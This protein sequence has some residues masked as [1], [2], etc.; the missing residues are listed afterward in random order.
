MKQ[1]DIF[2]GGEGDAWLTR[3]PHLGDRDPVLEAIVHLGLKP[4]SVFEIGCSNGWRLAALRDKFGCE[5]CGVDPSAHAIMEAANRKV[6]VWVGTADD[7]LVPD[8]D[9]DLVI[10]GF[11]LYLADPADYF[12]IAAEGDRVLEDG[13]YL[14]IYDF[15]IPCTAFARRYSHRN[16]VLSYHTDFSELWL[17]HPWYRLVD[18]KNDS[19]TDS[20]VT[21][22][23]K[24]IANAFPVLP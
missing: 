14:I 7:L 16:D 12:L 20:C 6:A 23:R 2:K 11:C 13:G 15:S 5:V 24:D 21:I 18:C 3:N 8:A 4:R 1:A 22:L 17:A 19:I 10:Y 9:F